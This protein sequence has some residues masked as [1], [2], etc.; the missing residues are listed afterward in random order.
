MMCFLRKTRFV[1]ILV[2]SILQQSA[3]WI[4]F[5][6]KVWLRLDNWLGNSGFGYASE[7]G[8]IKFKFKVKTA[9]QLHKSAILKV[10][11]RKKFRGKKRQGKMKSKFNPMPKQHSSCWKSVKQRKSETPLIFLIKFLFLP[12]HRH[13]FYLVNRW[14]AKVTKI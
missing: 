11:F 6:G 1:N 12:L 3:S 4:C 14:Q 8:Q 9:K 13:F 2:G 5:S 7:V 10:H